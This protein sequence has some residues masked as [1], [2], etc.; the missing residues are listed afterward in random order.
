MNH[1]RGKRQ[2]LVVAVSMD[3]GFRAQALDSS[4]ST[5]TEPPCASVSLSGLVGVCSF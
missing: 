1:P 3:S 5:K 2:S 4:S